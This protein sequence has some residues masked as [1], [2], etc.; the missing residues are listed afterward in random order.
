MALST[1]E[2]KYIALTKAIKEAQWLQGLYT[3]IQQPIPRA[4]ALY[5][6]NT[7]AIATTK[8][9]KHHQRTKHTL[10]KFIYTKEA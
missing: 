5:S 1:L 10:V 2:A 4:I 3:K 7:G 9:P 8:D 6:N